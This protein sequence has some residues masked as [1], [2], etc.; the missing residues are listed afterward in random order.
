MYLHV[1]F[2]FLSTENQGLPANRQTLINVRKERVCVRFY[3]SNLTLVSIPSFPQ[4]INKLRIKI[5][6]KNVN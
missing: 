6:K 2:Y 5:S 4:N 3:I 1:N